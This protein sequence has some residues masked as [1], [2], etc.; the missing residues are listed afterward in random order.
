MAAAHKTLRALRR[1]MALSFAFPPRMSMER[2]SSDIAPA[3]F[4]PLSPGFG[5]EA[6][7]V[8]LRDLSDASWRELE[9]AFYEHQILALRTPRTLGRAVR[10]VRE[11]LRSRRSRT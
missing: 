7:G 2:V 8:D 4:T 6:S 10:R 9:R 1:N 3:S 5:I 11:A